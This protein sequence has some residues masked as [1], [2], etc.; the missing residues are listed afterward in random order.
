MK[1][2]TVLIAT[3]LSSV[4][5]LQPSVTANEAEIEA[6]SK[7]TLD[8]KREAALYVKEKRALFKTLFNTHMQLELEAKN[9]AEQYLNKA[10]EQ[11][12]G[13]L[14]EGVNTE[15][16]P[17]TQISKV[18]QLTYGN[19]LLPKIVYAPVS[20]S[21]LSVDDI[22]QALQMKN[23]ER[24]DIEG[25][26]IKYVRL[27]ISKSK[28][29]D[30]LNEAHSAL[31]ADNYT[32]ARDQILGAQKSMLFE[33]NG[34]QVPETI[35]K[36]HVSLARFLVK[37][38]EYEGARGALASAEAA[39]IDMKIDKGIAGK[40]SSNIV[41]IRQ[42]MKEVDVLITRR[43]PSLAQQIDKKLESWW[44]ALS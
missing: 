44:H 27:Q 17:E 16:L 22:A 43:D 39:M 11:L 9:Q 21:I 14:E 34:A 36:D 20:D 41:K 12:E 15:T 6:L 31:T 3:T 32:A 19:S 25:A 29:L 24:G 28:L 37:S 4:M 30:K 18:I 42:E 13:A 10:Y 26:K 7:T 38:A 35:V 5:L 1:K 40:S 33:F 2:T 8:I 23:I